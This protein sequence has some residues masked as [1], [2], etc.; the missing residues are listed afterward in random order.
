LLLGACA[1]GQTGVSVVPAAA[2]EATA[3]ADDDDF[4]EL[5]AQLRSDL[6]RQISREVARKPSVTPTAKTAK[7]RDKE[8]ADKANALFAPLSTIRMPI[9]GITSSNLYDSWGDPREGGR[10][11]HRGIDIFAPRGAQVVAV[12]DGI[13]SFIGE[14]PK[15]GQCIWLTTESGRSFYYAHLDRWAPGLYEGMEVQSGD[16][17]GFVGNTGNAVSTPPHL[18]FGINEDDEMVNP[19]PVLTRALP[20]KRAQVHVEVSG[21][22]SSR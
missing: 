1:T 3:P 6:N 7:A 20:V 10:R 12:A 4:S 15:G 9:V 17:I 16:L 8:F 11:R 13:I 19:F 18:H 21:G 5:L 14:Q 22:Y 2:E